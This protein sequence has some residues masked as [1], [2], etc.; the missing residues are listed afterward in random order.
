[1]LADETLQTT[2]SSLT[3][4]TVPI[5]P[6]DPQGSQVPLVPVSDGTVSWAGSRVSVPKP[7]HGNRPR[8]PGLP[9][10][11]ADWDGWDGS[12]GM[13]AG[14]RESQPSGDSQPCP[15]GDWHPSR[16]ARITW[17]DPVRL[18]KRITRPID[19]T[20]CRRTCRSDQNAQSRYHQ[21]L[22]KPFWWFW[23]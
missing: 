7:S 18:A 4:G 22:R 12:P 10:S 14:Q 15:S 21:N 20:Q 2:E 16:P 8:I 13:R 6:I 23:R 1:M 9:G 5:G 17:W 11:W 19:K 3:P